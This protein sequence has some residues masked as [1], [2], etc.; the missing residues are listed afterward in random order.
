MSKKASCTFSACIVWASCDQIFGFHLDLSRTGS[1]RS[2]RGVSLW[3]STNRIGKKFWPQLPK[4]KNRL[5]NLPRN[6][7]CQ[8]QRKASMT[9]RKA[10][11]TAT[12]RKLRNVN[13][14]SLTWKSAKKKLILLTLSNQ[15]TF[16]SIPSRTLLWWEG[17]FNEF[18]S[19]VNEVIFLH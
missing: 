2:K 5:K 14:S 3:P 1:K 10:A 19:C 4:V 15:I 9:K 16:L 6:R 7:W 18:N 13:P 11:M 12:R 8:V 17:Y